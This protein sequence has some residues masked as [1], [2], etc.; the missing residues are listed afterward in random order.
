[1]QAINRMRVAN[2]ASA[3]LAMAFRGRGSVA[4]AIGRPLRAGGPSV[5]FSQ[6]VTAVAA[7]VDREM[8]D[9]KA[10]CRWLAL[11]E[12]LYGD[13][14]ADLSRARYVTVRSEPDRRGFVCTFRATPSIF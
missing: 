1:M 12:Q 5:R 2:G 3:F 4:D 6:A 8:A 9:A 10:R 11:V 13:G 7:D 14:Y